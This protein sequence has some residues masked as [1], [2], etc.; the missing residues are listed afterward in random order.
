MRTRAKTVSPVAAAD[1][2][3]GHFT[4]PADVDLAKFRVCLEMDRLPE[5]SA[6]VIVN[7][8]FSGGVIG[9]PSRL[10]ITDHL[11][12]GEN[13]VV[14]EPLAPQSARIAFY[15]KAAQ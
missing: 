6:A 4:V 9:R 14:I 2:F 3:H 1:P 10:D 11:K 5:D 15:A 7:G 13:T 8:A 12:S